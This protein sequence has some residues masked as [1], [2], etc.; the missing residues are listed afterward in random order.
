MYIIWWAQKAGKHKCI[1]NL[2]YELHILQYFVYYLNKLFQKKLL[3][4]LDKNTFLP[5][6]VQ[7]SPCQTRYSILECLIQPHQKE[8]PR[9]THSC[10]KLGCHRLITF[11]FSI[12]YQHWWGWADTASCQH[13][14]N[15]AYCTTVC[16]SASGHQSFYFV[17][18]FNRSYPSGNLYPAETVSPFSFLAENVS[19]LSQT[20]RGMA[21]NLVTLPWWG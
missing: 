3:V 12:T 14:K 4:I 15:G 18:C 8:E 13:R 7:Y 20:L 5:H 21:F 16:A 11:F 19:H 2:L 9:L 10:V 1:T 17:N 6:C